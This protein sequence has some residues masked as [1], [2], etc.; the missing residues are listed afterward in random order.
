MVSYTYTNSEDNNP[1]GRFLDPFDP[2]LDVGPSG[3]ERRHAI[4]ASGSVL[5]PGDVTVGTVWS[6]R[7]PLPWTASAGRDLNRD[8]FASDLVPGTT[9]N[10]GSR[11][12]NL[13]AV[14]AYRAENNLAPVSESDID[15]SRI[16]IF[17]VRVSKSVR[18]PGDRKVD[19]IAQAFNLFNT[20]NLQS[21]FGSGR[22]GNALSATFG[23]ILSARP[24][25]QI[26]LAVRVNW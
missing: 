8:G 15:S 16:N 4:V 6:Y 1:M 24:A 23:R 2:T 10:S 14:N 13:D 25:R 5:L 19:L 18:V 3:G 11:N 20:T 22:V 17:D 26:E 12:L 21:Q 7:T 9:R